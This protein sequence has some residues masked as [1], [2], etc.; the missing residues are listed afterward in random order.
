MIMMPLHR[1]TLVIVL[2]LENITKALFSSSHK[3]PLLSQLTLTIEIF[4]SHPFK[5]GFVSLELGTC[6]EITPLKETRNG[7]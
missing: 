5:L 6:K 4:I 7:R 2:Y 1:M 3:P